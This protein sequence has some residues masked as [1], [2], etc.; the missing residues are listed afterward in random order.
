MV[1]FLKSFRKVTTFKKKFSQCSQSC[2]T[3]FIMTIK[4]RVNSGIMGPQ[5]TW[6]YYIY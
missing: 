5:V 4:S 3:R 2:V 6:D 1:C